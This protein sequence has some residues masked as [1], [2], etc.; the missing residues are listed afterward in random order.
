[1]ART[2]KI[3][4]ILVLAMNLISLSCNGQIMVTAT[5]YNAVPDQ[6]DSD[7]LITA[8][9]KQIDPNNPQRWIAVSRDLEELGITLGSKVCIDNAGEMNGE[10]V[11]EDRMN[12]RWRRRIDFLVHDSIR[13]GKWTNVKIRIK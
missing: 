1:M 6:T 10:W 7:P 9:L 2:I 5:V 3:L 8:S 4:V 13:L 11:V 12:R